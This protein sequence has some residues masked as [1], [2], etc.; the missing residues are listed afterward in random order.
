M[1][2]DI[3]D[4]QFSLHSVD[5]SSE[6]EA[7]ELSSSSK[8]NQEG[9]PALVLS[10]KRLAPE[11]STTRASS[12]AASSSSSN[13]PAKLSKRQKKMARLRKKHQENGTDKTFG[14]VYST[15]SREET[16]ECLNRLGATYTSVDSPIS[17][18]QV[19]L[20]RKPA[21]EVVFSVQSAL[22]QLAPDSWQ[23]KFCQANEAGATT[24]RAF[25]LTHSALRVLELQKSLFGTPFHHAKT[26]EKDSG[27]KSRIVVAPLFARHKKVQEQI[28]FMLQR[29]VLVA[30]GT[31]ARVQQILEQEASLLKKI[32]WLVIDMQPNSKGFTILENTDTAKP[33][34]QLLFQVCKV[35]ID[36]NKLKIALF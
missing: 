27:S 22:Q 15:W 34:F 16:S 18:K 33:V 1:A 35:L 3:D 5:S 2:D 25:V 28:D 17:H 7:A 21:D 36:K 24:P 9:H 29:Q 4:N 32:E 14:H 19:V 30:I 8:R 6:D 26:E 13:K 31:P 23:Q 11:A 20:L 12:S 10:R